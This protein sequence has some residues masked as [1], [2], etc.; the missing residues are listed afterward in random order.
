MKWDLVPSANPLH[1]DTLIPAALS[2]AKSD[3]APSHPPVHIVKR[4]EFVHARASQSV[5]VHDTATNHLHVFIKGSFERVKQISAADSLPAN[6]DAVAAKYA[7]EGCYVLSIAHRD[8]GVVGTDVE[9]EQVKGWSREQ[10][11]SHARFMG[12]VLFRNKLKEDTPAAIAE[13]KGG[14]TRAVMITGDNALTGVYIARQCGMIGEGQRVVLG[15][16]VA[17]EVAWRNVD[18]G[19]VVDVEEAIKD[20]KFKPVE[21]A[22]T[23]KAFEV[24]VRE[25]KMK[26]LLLDTRIF[27][28]MTPNDKV[29]CVQLHM[30]KGITGACNILV[31]YL[32]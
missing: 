24:L 31:L 15:D 2:P 26:E 5:A 28:R 1:L 4:F 12:L 23:G 30:E 16:L 17:G 22:V 19:D 21:L 32:L 7:Q 11:E 27:A 14:D 25:E 20:K 10:L 18:N 29:K 9:I 8:L 6:Y 3:S 13:L